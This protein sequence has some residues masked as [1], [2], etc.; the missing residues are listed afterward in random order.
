MVTKISLALLAVLIL[1]A[2]AGEQRNW[3]FVQAVGGM[4]LG[5]PYRTPAGMMLPVEIDVT[6]LRSFTTK[7]TIMNSGLALK[8]IVVRRQGNKILLK[9]LTT[10]AGKGSSPSSKDL[11]LGSLEPG[12]YSVLFTEPD[13]ATVEVGNITVPP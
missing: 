5:A 1:G 9:V 8:E 10:I 13:G 6:G 12:R 7:A 2:C 4:A 11:L 3:A